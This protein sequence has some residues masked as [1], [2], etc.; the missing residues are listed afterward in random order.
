MKFDDHPHCL[1]ALNRL[2]PF[3]DRELS[4]KEMDEVRQHL[5][6]CPPCQDYFDLQD[7]FKMLVRRKACPEKAP[8]ELVQRILHRIREN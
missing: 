6:D 7:G 2:H 3:L 4:P 1:T 8:Q 5:V